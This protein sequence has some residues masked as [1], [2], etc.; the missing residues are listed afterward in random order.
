LSFE[1]PARDTAVCFSR[2]SAVRRPSVG[3]TLDAI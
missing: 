1:L 3:M 2:Q